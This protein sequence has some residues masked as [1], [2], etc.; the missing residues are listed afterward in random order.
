MRKLAAAHPIMPIC[1]LLA[2]KPCLVVGGGP[3][4]ARKTSHLLEAQADVTVVSPK[5]CPKLRALARAKKIRILP[6]AFT[7]SDVSGKYLVFAATDNTAVNRQ[8]L[9]KCRKCG[10]LCSAADSNWPQ[11][12]FVMPA[13]TRRNGLV[14][15]VSTGGRSCRQARLVKEK[16]AALLETLADESKE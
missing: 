7:A 14:V 4:A 9:A 12:D 13:T 16:I 10:I 5:T 11:G 6:R 8:V 15:T 1:L 3:I 2:G